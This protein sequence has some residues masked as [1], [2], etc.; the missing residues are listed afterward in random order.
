M[1]SIRAACSSV[2]DQEI[3]CLREVLGRFIQS[4]PPEICDKTVEKI[5]IALVDIGSHYELKQIFTKGKSHVVANTHV[6]QISLCMT[7]FLL[8]CINIHYSQL[9]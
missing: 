4:Q 5:A 7:C 9:L 1:M 6:L 2:I 3:C 8:R